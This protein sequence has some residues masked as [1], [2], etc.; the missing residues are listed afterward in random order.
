VSSVHVRLVVA[1]YF[2]QI[3]DLAPRA[4]NRW[5]HSA[6][7]EHFVAPSPPR[8]RPHGPIV[9]DERHPRLSNCR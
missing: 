9:D 1:H 6:Q 4:L 5:L 7:N 3:E 8:D 2:L